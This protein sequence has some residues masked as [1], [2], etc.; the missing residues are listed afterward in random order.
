M[1]PFGWMILAFALLMVGVCGFTYVQ[2]LR[3]D[4]QQH[5]NGSS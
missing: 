3:N 5:R 4:H 2:I 1:T